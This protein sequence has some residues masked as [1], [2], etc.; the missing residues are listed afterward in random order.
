M[1]I[2]NSPVLI[3]GWEDL[4]PSVRKHLEE[5]MVTVQLDLTS[6][7]EKDFSSSVR[8]QIRLHATVIF[9]YFAK[10]TLIKFVP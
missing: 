2:R 5:N 8:K 9:K 4:L 3:L 10:S 7:K 6:I 1:K